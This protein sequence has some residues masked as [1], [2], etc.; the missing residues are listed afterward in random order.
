MIFAGFAASIDAE[1][2]GGARAYASR[3][4]EIIICDA[5]SSVN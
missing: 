3:R 2:R 5:N 1:K 4:G